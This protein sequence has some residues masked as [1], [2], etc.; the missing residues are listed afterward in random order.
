MN[1]AM[2][3]TAGKLMGPESSLYLK[4][5]PKHQIDTLNDE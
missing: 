4:W 5:P 2:R 1:Q 3:E